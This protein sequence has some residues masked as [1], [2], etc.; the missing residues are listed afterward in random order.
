MRCRKEST[1]SEVGPMLATNISEMK[2]TQQRA[3]LGQNRRLDSITR[4]LLSHARHRHCL[5]GRAV[6][7]P[8]TVIQIRCREEYR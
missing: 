8:T 3:G 7:V 2:M 1:D 5:D 6:T 4:E